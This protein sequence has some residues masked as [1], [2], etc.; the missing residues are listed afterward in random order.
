MDI[1]MQINKTIF[2]QKL[3]KVSGQFEDMYIS[4]QISKLIQFQWELQLKV[5]RKRWR[6]GMYLADCGLSAALPA[7][8]ST[9]TLPGGR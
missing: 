4:N 1:P 7:A 8:T 3:G 2:S 6:C 9:L 5:E